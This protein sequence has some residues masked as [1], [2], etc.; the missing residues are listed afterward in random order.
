MAEGEKQ[1]EKY[2][3]KPRREKSRARGE[4]IE[5]GAKNASSNMGERTAKTREKG[6]G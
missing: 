5:R 6:A 1:E 2:K 3:Q 4:G